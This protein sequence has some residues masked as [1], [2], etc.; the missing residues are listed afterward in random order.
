MTP[1]TCTTAART[2]G[3]VAGLALTAVSCGGGVRRWIMAVVAGV[4]VLSGCRGTRSP[5]EESS[6]TTE[7]TEPAAL[8][9]VAFGDSWS[10][11]AHC[12]GCEPFPVLVAEGLEADQGAPVAFENLTTNGGTTQSL[13]DS[14]ETSASTRDAIAGADLIVINTGANDLEPAINEWAA[15]RGCGGA[16]GLDCFRV[17]A[18]GWRT[19][20]DGILAEIDDLRAGEATAVRVI[21][22]SNEFLADPGLIATFGA[23]FGPTGGAAITAMHH[24]ALCEASAAHG[25]ACV[26]LRPVLNGPDLTT[27][28]DVNTQEAMQ[29]VADAIFATGLP[30][31]ARD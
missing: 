23:E 16:D 2:V 7:A 24:D 1:T 25:A 10:F 20:F 17:V 6:A 12:G 26:D 3:S 5:E 31:L 21:S 11:G 29:A 18:E 19:G 30:E 9:Y 8:A 22:N 14:I 15:T 28:Q 13:L 27:P 4:I